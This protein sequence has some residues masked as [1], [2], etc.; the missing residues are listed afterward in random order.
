MPKFLPGL[1]NDTGSSASA[2]T[3]SLLQ[4]LDFLIRHAAQLAQFNQQERGSTLDTGQISIRPRKVNLH[5]LVSST[6]KPPI[7]I[8]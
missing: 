7:S 5:R 4:Q 8:S 6:K 1:F 2:I 3:L